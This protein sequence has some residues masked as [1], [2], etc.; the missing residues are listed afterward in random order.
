M[1]QL[2][3]A[4][5]GLAV[6]TLLMPAGLFARLSVGTAALLWALLTMTYELD[7]PVYATMRAAMPSGCWSALFSLIAL[8]EFSSLLFRCNGRAMPLILGGIACVW[9]FMAI[10][11][12]VSVSPPA[13]GAAGEVVVAIQACWLFLRRALLNDPAHGKH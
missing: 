2:C 7:R 6:K 3:T 11:M 5:K 10:S 12:L 1:K 4:A 13:A 8:F 9:V